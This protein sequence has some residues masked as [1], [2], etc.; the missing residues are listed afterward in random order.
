MLIRSRARPKP[1]IGQ[2][3]Y[4]KEYGAQPHDAFGSSSVIGI[5]G[6]CVTVHTTGPTPTNEVGFIYLGRSEYEVV[7]F[8]LIHRRSARFAVE[9]VSFTGDE[10]CEDV[11]SARFAIGDDAFGKPAADIEAFLIAKNY[12]PDIARIVAA[13]MSAGLS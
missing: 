13:V 6:E 4:I 5:Q 3:A 9:T 12:K 11:A 7:T 8:D 1:G 2:A 10:R